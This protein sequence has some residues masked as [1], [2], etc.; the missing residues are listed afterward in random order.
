M[1]VTPVIKTCS[2]CFEEKNSDIISWC[3]CGE[4][5]YVCHDCL[6]K[7]KTE[8]RNKKL[9]QNCSICKQKQLTNLP[10][11]LSGV[12]FSSILV[13]ILTRENQVS[14]EDTHDLENPEEQNINN[15]NTHTIYEEIQR[16][17][18]R[19]LIWFLVFLIISWMFAPFSYFII[20]RIKNDYFKEFYIT[21]S[22]GMIFGFPLTIILRRSI[23]R[24]CFPS[25]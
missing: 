21:L 5:S 22:T 14:R 20:F 8:L 18:Y 7:G 17:L 19:G 23:R 13:T 4:S 16:R 1:R 24:Y 6:G 3:T 9:I 15:E 11:K 10:K 12:K 2:W 25:E